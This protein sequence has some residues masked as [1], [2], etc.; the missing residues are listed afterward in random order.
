[1]RMI[2]KESTVDGETVLIR[3]A[4]DLVDASALS[5]ARECAEEVAPGAL[6][7]YAFLVGISDG[8]EPIAPESIGVP[9][10]CFSALLAN[11]RQGFT[12]EPRF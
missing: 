10:S 7:A 1:M 4:G 11:E 5:W 8:G 6:S 9:A 2:W 12:E 3:V